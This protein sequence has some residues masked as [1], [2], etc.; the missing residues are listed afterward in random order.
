M[1]TRSRCPFC[2]SEEIYCLL[3]TL[4][5]KRCKNVWK[6]EK[7]DPGTDA[8]RSAVQL[9]NPLLKLPEKTAPLETRMKKRLDLVLSRHNGK[10]SMDAIAEN[11][12]DISPDLF[13]RYL[14]RCVKTRILTETK[15][16]SGRTWY[17]RR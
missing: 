15:D 12:G 16:R 5:C 7:N 10:F 9:Q 11:A 4:H 17:S 3:D 1:T 2:S 13:R 14:R 6:E 8:C